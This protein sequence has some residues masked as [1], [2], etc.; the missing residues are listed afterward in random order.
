MIFR[1]LHRPADQFGSNRSGYVQV[2]VVSGESGPLGLLVMT[3]DE[4]EMWRS[5]MLDNNIAVDLPAH[6]QER[7]H[8]YSMEFR[9]DTSIV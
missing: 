3:A 8:G 4:W 9:P 1:L 5:V 2:R 6:A 7:N